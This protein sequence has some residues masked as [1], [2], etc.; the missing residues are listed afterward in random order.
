VLISSPYFIPDRDF[1]D[2]IRALVGRGVRVAIVTNSLESNNHTVAHTGYRRWRRE[3]LAAGAELYELRADAEAIDLYATPP[4]SPG[5]LGLHTKAVVV[6]GGACF[7][8]S[9]NVDPRSM[10]LNTEIG[11]VVESEELSARVRELIMR[12]MAPENAWAVAMDDEGWL[13]WTS[14]RGTLTRQPA[15]DFKQRVVEFFLNLIPLKKQ[16]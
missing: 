14:E 5:A 11:V 9:P 10:E 2:L 8:G 4:V 16:A 3:I 7:I 6:D 12:D 1:R 15:R 13:T